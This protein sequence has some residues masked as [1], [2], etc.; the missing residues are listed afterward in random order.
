MFL[1]N[2]GYILASRNLKLTHSEITI[3]LIKSVSSGDGRISLISFIQEMHSDLITDNHQQYVLNNKNNTSGE[4][5]FPLNSSQQDKDKTKIISLK[6]YKNTQFIGI[7]SIGYPKQSI[8][9]IFDTG[10]GSLWVTS[11]LCNS[12]PCKKQI[13]YD[14]NKSK[15]FHRIGIDL[16]VTFGTAQI[17]GQIN[18]DTFYLTDLEIPNQKFG[19]I[20]EEKGDAFNQGNFSGILGLGYPAMSSDN[21]NPVFDSIMNMKLLKKNIMAFYYSYNQDTDGEITFGQINRDRYEGELRYYKVIDRYYWSI[22]MDD[23]LYD[24]VSLGYCKNG[25]CKAILD[26]G[27]TLVTGPTGQIRDLLSKLPLE[28]NC[29][30]YDK[31]R[32]LTFVLSGDKYDLDLE[33]YVIKSQTKS[34]SSSVIVSPNQFTC[35]ALIMP[36]DVPEPHGPAWV[37][38]NIFMEKFYSVYDRDFNRIGLAKAKHS[39]KKKNY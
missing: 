17:S 26:S 11:S 18:Q 7:I 38:G 3:K 6:N 39:E 27:T 37:F 31:T 16:E 25:P 23:I 32:K 21:V 22:Q 10:S 15:N 8:P 20:L 1:L 4:F 28:K 19:E 35:S 29:D 34:S 33:D 9:V 5:F 30:N 13:S 12:S 2:S 36:L 24:G 14:R